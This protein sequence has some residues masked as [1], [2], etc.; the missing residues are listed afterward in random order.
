ML[1][2]AVR[3]VHA[4]R[5]ILDPHTLD[6]YF[7]LFAADSNVPW[8][9]TTIRLETSTA[10]AVDF[11]A[12]AIDAAD[13]VT[14]GSSARA[15]AIDTRHLHPVATWRF[16]PQ[17]GYQFQSSDVNVPLGK[18]EGFF[19]IEARRGAVAEQVWID[20]TR[21]GLISQTAPNALLVYVTDLGTGRALAHARV[22]F[23]VGTSFV[24]RYT[25]AR[26][27]VR[28][29]DARRPIFA[30]AQWGNSQAFLSFVPQAPLP[31]KIVGIRADSAV[32][33][34]GDVLHLVGFA[35]TR[36]GNA[37]RPSTGS[38]SISM[39]LG[40]TPIAQKSV[41]LDEAGAFAASIEIPS[42][43]KAGEYA[44][45]AQ[46]D[47]AAGGA[48]VRVDAEADG[49][50]LSATPHCNGVCDPN[51]DVP[52]VV[53][54]LRGGRGVP[55]VNVR[56]VV[57]RSPHVFDDD[58]S[59]VPPWGITPWLDVAATT[60]GD[61]SATV[62]IPHPTDGLASTYGVT[63][64]GAGATA[65]TRVVV[66]TSTLAL[67]LRLDRASAAPETPIGF[68]LQAVN[69]VTQ[70]PVPNLAASI[71]VTHG[72][73]GSTLSVVTD[74]SGVAR[75][76]LP[77][78]SLGTSLVVARASLAGADASDAAQVQILPQSQTT[79]ATDT[80]A[81]V[82]VTPDRAAYRNGETARF[83]A[84]DAGS[85]G[86]ALMTLLCSAGIATSVVRS[87]AGT[88][89][90]TFKIE[91]APGDMSVAGAFVRDG[92]IEWNLAP[93]TVEAPGRPATLA[94]HLDRS[95]YAPGATAELAFDDD[96]DA[97]IVLRLSRGTPSGSARF[98]TLPGLLAFG[99]AATQNSAPSVP[100]WHPSIDSAGRSQSVGFA[101]RDGAL[102][103]P[104]LA[105]S[106]TR[107]VYWKVLRRSREAISI[108]LPQV[109]GTYTL[110]ILQIG[111][112]GRI[113][114]AS[115]NVTVR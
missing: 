53:R 18:R 81:V 36:I 74:A 80:S 39:R 110:S 52:V 2:A 31:S 34:A 32:A 77:A 8:K 87:D 47:G 24:T 99:V 114:A 66:P 95:A 65:E 68:T 79:V 109:R 105:E 20:R 48:V 58:A 9:P 35:R 12:Y 101:V 29:K 106:D 73:G 57:V 104:S 43:V 11:A 115:S 16:A 64:E 100:N 71:T 26:G 85:V 67:Q 96:T 4:G 44:V 50:A 5:A 49:L 113:A 19:V 45:L 23:V 30:L 78:P 17:G 103:E 91:P 72:G 27:I 89:S 15:R 22:Q 60:G 40:A 14:A 98:E 90:A 97:T 7:S 10:T 62:A 54:A 42:N 94:V 69:V 82:H 46:V 102:P 75:G 70:R 21:I 63:V 28:W 33:R 13:V 41:K 37:L 112:D 6:A 55:G 38:A 92:A 56:V 83:D 88:A 111:D 51:G 86:D 76:S 107:A 59:G 1:L 3:P 93:L 108:P 61:G 84:G 25:D